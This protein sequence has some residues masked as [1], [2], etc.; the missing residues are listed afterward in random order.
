M[1]TYPDPGIDEGAVNAPPE[2]MLPPLADHV[3][4]EL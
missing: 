1:V 3:T 2:E 4:A